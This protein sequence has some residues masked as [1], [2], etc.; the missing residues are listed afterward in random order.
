MS[1][2]QDR[3]EQREEQRAEL[4]GQILSFL[5]TLPE[6]EAFQN[7]RDISLDNSPQKAQAPRTAD[8]IISLTTYP[9][10]IDTL[11]YTLYTLFT[12][13]LAPKRVLLWLSKEEFESD[14]SVPSFLNLPTGVGGV[15]YP[16]LW[17][18]NHSESA[19][20]PIA[21]PRCAV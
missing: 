12:Q 9:A 19:P 2:H 11:H 16:P 17:P 14:K 6:C 4:E 15:L 3:A 21:T 5:D 8:V 20:P 1:K 18:L 13:S 10:R 7:L